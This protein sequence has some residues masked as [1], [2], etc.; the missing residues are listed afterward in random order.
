MASKWKAGILTA[1]LT[2]ST[3]STAYAGP[4]N[5]Q[6]DGNGHRRIQHVL[7]ISIDGMHVVDFANCVTSDTCPHLAELGESGVT[8]T[9][10]STSRPSDSFPGLMALVTGGTPRTVG[11]F[12]DVAYDRVLAP[13]ATTT[14]NGLAAGSCIQGVINGTQTE[15]EE[16]DEIDQTKVNGG[17][18][19]ASSI[20]GGI[21]S[22]DPTK[23]VR[24]P[25]NGCKPVYPWN[26]VRTNTIYGVI[27]KAG[28]YTAWS[29]K[30]AVY[31]VVSGPTGTS[32][33]SNVDDYYSP[34][35]NSNQVPLA[36]I[37]TAGTNFDCSQIAASGND[38]TTDFQAIQCYDQLKVNGIVNQ[39]KG[40]KHL[41][42]GDAPVPAIFGMNF[43]AV[44][45]GQKLIENG[46]KGGYTDAAGDPTPSMASEIKFVDAG[47][48]QMVEE[49]QD[50]HLLSSTAIII[51]AKHGQSPIDT[52]RFFPIPGNS[53]LNGTPPSGII[54]TLLPLSATT[55]LGL[56]EDDISQLWLTNSNDTLTAVGM[57][58]S[59][60][61]KAGIGQILY[62]TSLNTIFNPPG[63]PTTPGPCCFLREGG[64]PRTPDIIVLPNVGVVYT[65]STKKQSEHGG[66]A[67]DDTNVMLL[68]SN[69]GY[70]AQTL[71]SFVETTQVA[72]TILKLLGL[73]P[74]EL[75][76]VRK[77]GT[78]VLPGI[79]F[80]DGE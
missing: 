27:H 16:G 39:I 80:G 32:L 67:W 52:N 28:G 65:G 62:G 75:D 48:G 46:V 33:P 34:E 54:G 71:H 3:M 49:L 57:L 78:P 64:D 66:F 59:N 10:T 40:K 50:R 14:G 4:K 2:L 11:A 9:R 69:P 45:V 24:D 21:L 30:H 53:G 73:D 1:A 17:G 61:A 44:S 37:T 43:Q 23:L 41:G 26:F 13:P 8:Y 42:V 7:L 77:E 35:V 15:Y 63:V 76:A 51:T 68:V 5:G 25:F 60:A 29:D 72:P 70:K 58:E 31:A 20:D 36:G 74:D 18:P 55:G 22:I 38:W 19:Y 47:I 56:A 79:D 6:W 12:Y